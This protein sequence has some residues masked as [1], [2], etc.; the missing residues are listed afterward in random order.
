MVER[1]KIYCLLVTIRYVVIAKLRNDFYD[2]LNVL[3]NNY[4][5]GSVQ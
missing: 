4:I 3:K 2:Y 1:V 5:S